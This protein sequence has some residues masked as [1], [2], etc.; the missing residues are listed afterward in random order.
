M[1]HCDCIF[2][3]I[4]S[5]QISSN[6]VYEDDQI[7]AFKDVAPQTPVHIVLIPKTHISGL[8][9][10]TDKSA[11]IVTHITMIA[12]MLA[13]NFNIEMSGYRLISNCGPDAGQSIHHLHFHLLGGAPMSVSLV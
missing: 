13:K 7:I 5:K 10:L 8:N 3:Q 2:C 12:K 1:S 6:I 9:E 11:T 4:V